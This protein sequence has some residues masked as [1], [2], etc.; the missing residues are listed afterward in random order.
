LVE[1]LNDKDAIVRKLKIEMDRAKQ[2]KQFIQTKMP[3][4]E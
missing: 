1:K 2:D 3:C 4:V